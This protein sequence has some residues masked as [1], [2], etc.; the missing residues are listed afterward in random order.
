VDVRTLAEISFEMPTSIT[1]VHEQLF[2]G[3]GIVRVDVPS[4][5]TKIHR[6]WFLKCSSLTIVTFY[7]DSRHNTIA[8]EAFSYIQWQEKLVCTGTVGYIP[9]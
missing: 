6:S 7:D 5:V 3:N 8:E 1:D 9:V 2:S 4:T